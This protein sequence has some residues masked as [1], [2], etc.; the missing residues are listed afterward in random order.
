MK[1]PRF[2]A[3]RSSLPPG[4]PRRAALVRAAAALSAALVLLVLGLLDRDRAAPPRPGGESGGA[5]P[6]G[7]PVATSPSLPPGATSPRAAGKLG[8]AAAAP[9]VET[10]SGAVG[11]AEVAARQRA[12]LEVAP[13]TE[14]ALRLSRRAIPAGQGIHVP[15]VD[16]HILADELAS[17][18]PEVRVVEPA[19]L[20]DR[21]IARL[22][23]T[24]ARH[25][26]GAER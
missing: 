8:S 10:A 19:D 20:R 16:V 7:A 11:L 6:P 1:L 23:A 9:G 14:A 4:S 17:Y 3:T 15:Y 22:E 2:P 21:V 26:D 18:G 24:L 25:R 13:G 5:A 12:L